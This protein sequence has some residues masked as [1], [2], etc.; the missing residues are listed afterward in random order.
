MQK[1]S[2]IESPVKGEVVPQGEKIRALID[3]EMWDELTDVLGEWPVPDIAD[4][5]LKSTKSERV[6]IF[7]AL[8]REKAAKVFAFLD[9]YTQ[10][11]LLKELTDQETRKILKTIPPDDR[12]QFLEELP[13]RLTRKLLNLL[14]GEHLEEARE[15]LGYPEESVG[16]LMTPDYVR[17]KPDWTCQ[18]ALDH[19]RKIG[20]DKE[21]IKSIYVVDEENVLIDAI[22]LRQI[23]LTDPDTQIEELMDYS[24]VSVE[25]NADREE[26]VQIMQ[27]YD[28]FS[29]PAE[30]SNGR[31]LGIVTI[32]DALDVAEEEAT[33][34]F[35][36]TSAV[37]PLGK[38][39]SEA[40]VGL[41]F[42]SR[43]WWLLI[44]VFVN[45]ISSG[46]I[47]GFEETLEA[48][49]GLA[50]FI[51]L[52]IDS[53]GNAGAQSA[54]MMVRAISIGDVQMDEWFKAFLREIAIGLFLGLSLGF[55]SFFL[56]VFRAEVMIGVVVGLAMLAI[57]FAANLIGVLLPF[58]L[59]TLNLDP[60]VASG[61]LI[62]SIVDACGLLIYFS[63]AMAIL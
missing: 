15:L 58:L 10:N 48:A 46:I 24:Y 17:V 36:K 3:R 38:T 16:R 45:L 29:I 14:E 23:I 21:T 52:L 4:L 54:M 30:D 41:L 9:S 19:I 62:T 6:F 59:T 37:L 39:Y 13:A 8:D 25:A 60:A 50:F 33:E 27:R 49:I 57:I 61:P 55:A 31:L 63:I 20:K 56:G 2:A 44:L 51:P 11:T 47:A 5:L 53:G 40:G 34:D 12:T 22:P 43:F 28:L 18:E 35:Q 32:D 1:K 42:R 7:R 26:A